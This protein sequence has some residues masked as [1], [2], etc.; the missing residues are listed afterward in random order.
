MSITSNKHV[1][2]R[3]LSHF[4]TAGANELL[5]ML[6]DDAT[7]WVNGKPHLFAFSGSKTKAEMRP[8][9]HDLFAFFD[10]GLKMQLNSSIG[11]GD[12]V[13]AEARS[14]GKT[15]SGKRYENEYHILFRLRD[16]KIAEV[17][18]YTDPMHAVEVMTA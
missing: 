11:E 1:V 10:G 4:E 3:F 6:T 5:A 8:V 18:E 12:T 14:L 2:E 16:G 13:A 15:K 9:L 17:R 7:W